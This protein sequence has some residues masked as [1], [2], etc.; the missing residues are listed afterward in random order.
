MLFLMRIRITV[1]TYSSVPSICMNTQSSDENCGLRLATQLE[2][3]EREL[4]SIQ[5]RKSA[6]A[7]DLL[8][9]D[10]VEVGQSGR[11]Y[12]KDQI[13]ATLAAEPSSEIFSEKYQVKRLGA[14]VALV[15]YR[16]YR[17]TGDDSVLRSSI[18]CKRN[19]HWQLVY[20]QGTPSRG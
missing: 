10:F 3:L 17:N 6:R 4:H 14:D 15:T 1:D 20:H 16:S 9:D 12:N 19:T 2:S 11:C 5:V 8:A 13:L 18:W 7:A